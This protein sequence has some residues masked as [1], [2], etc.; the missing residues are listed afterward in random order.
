MLE[1]RAMIPTNYHNSQIALPTLD[2]LALL[3]QYTREI[4]LA[5]MKHRQNARRREAL[6]SSL[7]LPDVADWIESHCFNAAKVVNPE[8]PTFQSLIKL[9]PFQRRILRKVF[10]ID[11]R[12]GRFPYRTVVYSAPKKSGKSS[13]GA[14]VSCYFVANV[15]APNAVYVLANDREQ[16]STRVF[17]FARPTL[18][19]LGGRRDGK[20]KI[21]L[22]NGSYLLASTSEPE[23]EAGGSYGLT[24]FDEL[25][26]YTT[27]RSKLLWDELR[28][29]G[30]RQNSVRFVVTYA[31][32]EDSSDLLLKLFNKIFANTKETEL[33]PGA[34]PVPELIDITTTDGE[35]NVIPCCYEVPEIGLFYFNDH[36]QR[37]F[38]QQGEHGEA[39]IRETQA[40]ETEE[41][42]FRLTY[43]RWQLTESRFVD[44][45]TL[46]ASFGKSLP[47][48]KP[49][50][51]GV[52]AGWKKDCSALVGTF[53][54]DDRYVTAYCKIWT[55]KDDGGLDLD[56]TIG[57]EIVRLFRVGLIARRE[58][59]PGERKLVEKEQLI[60]LD[61]WYD[62][63]QL[64]QVMMNLRKNHKLLIAKFD[65][66]RLRLLSDTFL[67]DCYNQFRIDNL[68][69]S[70]LQ[71]HLEAAKAVTQLDA[72][73]TVIRIVK[74][75][76][77]H[78]HPIDASVAQS[79][80]VYRR[81]QR[82]ILAG[83]GIAQ[84]KTKGW[85]KR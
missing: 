10:T 35:G 14:F 59:E 25:W 45:P 66:G 27:P 75:T 51:F 61:V 76:G 9:E 7:A 60:C 21:I 8:S 82:P 81:S 50:T 54:N 43:N 74:G 72:S 83:F 41:N 31:G 67:Q 80:S 3:D 77:Q 16:S 69:D 19:A 4:L 46:G 65:Q 24:V 18:Y 53:D 32:F 63:T 20:Y 34:R 47:V 85:T 38:W 23:K 30:T 68:S 44:V 2:D 56:A 37:M 15:E 49:M 12:T 13:I 40:L 64:H 52:D 6:A 28:P 62:E 29:I 26:A 11:P 36:E 78:A 1:F 57:A 39:L 33:S 79:M 70:G 84:G 71:S 17:A 22:P 48:T 5:Q 73:R 58:P 55:P 42:T